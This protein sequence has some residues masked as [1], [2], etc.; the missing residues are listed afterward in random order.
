[1]VKPDLDPTRNQLSAC[2]PLLV[3]HLTTEEQSSF[4]KTDSTFTI[5]MRIYDLLAIFQKYL[6]LFQS[7][8]NI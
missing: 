7:F 1:M 6:I 8:A 3:T 4:W 2:S 5:Y